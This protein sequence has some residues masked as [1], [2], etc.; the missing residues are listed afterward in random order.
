MERVESKVVMQ[1]VC[2]CDGW[3][4]HSVSYIQVEL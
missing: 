1:K 3:N 4:I 2:M